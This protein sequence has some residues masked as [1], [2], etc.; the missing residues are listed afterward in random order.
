MELKSCFKNECS[1]G[2]PAHLG[3]WTVLRGRSLEKLRHGPNWA[4]PSREAG[5]A[6]VHHNRNSSLYRGQFFET[7]KDLEPG[8]LILLI[9]HENLCV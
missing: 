6:D 8:M 7:L 1:H 4:C 5:R 3:V 2:L 9:Y